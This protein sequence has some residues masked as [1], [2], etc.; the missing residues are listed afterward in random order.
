MKKSLSLLVAIA[1]VFSMFATVV[2][3]AEEPTAGEYLNELGVILGNQDGDL[4]EDQTWKRQDIVVLLSR[5]FGAEDEA[6]GA[7]KTHEFKD[8]TDKNYDGY[9][10]WAVEEGLVKGK[11]ATVFGFGDELENRDFYLLVLRALG[12]EVDYDKVG[13][14]A[15]EAGLAPEDT[16]FDDIPLRGE[17][18]TAI[19]AALK[20]E[21]EPG[22]TLEQKLGL[23]EIVDL[24]INK[25]AQTNKGEITVSFN[26]AATAD[27]QK[28]LKAKVA[29]GA[30][31]YTVTSKWAEDGKSL[32]LTSTYLPAATYTVTVGS[33]KAVD[34]TIVNEVP[35]KLEIGATTLQ[36]AA[37]Q[38]LKVKLFNQFGKEIENASL[39]VTVF[40]ATYGKTVAVSSGKV[41]LSSDEVAR[42]K[43]TVV[44]NA[45]HATTG[46]NASKSFEVVAGS[47]A[48]AIT[49]TAPTPLKDKTRISVTEEGLVLP[50]TLTDQYGGAIKLAET[51]GY[52]AIS[53]DKTITLS[54]ITFLV[55]DVNIVT[56]F[57]VDKD[58]VLKFKTGAQHGNVVVNAMNT[59]VAGAFASV[60]FNV[61]S[62]ADVKTLTLQAP[63]AIVAGNE[64]FTV[65]YSAVDTFDQPIATKDFSLTGLTFSPVGAS[66]AA[67]YPKLNAKGELKFKFQSLSADANVNVYVSKA[68]S[69]QIGH[70]QFT[71]RKDATVDKINGFNVAKNFANSGTV[72]LKADQIT[73]RDSYGRT[74]KVAALGDVAIS[75]T[76]GTALSITGGN[77]VANATLTGEVKIKVVYGG[78]D[79]TAETFTFNVIKNE[80][81][82]D[83][84]IKSIGTMYAGTVPTGVAVDA[85]EKTIELVGKTSGG[86][87]VVLNQATA[88]D[89]VSSEKSLIVQVKTGSPKTIKAVDAGTS[90]IAAYKG[91]TKL[92]Q[93]E[94]TA[95]KEAPV[96]TT[97]S[98]DN[99]EYTLTTASTNFATEIVVKDQYG[100][101]L[102]PGTHFAGFLS[103]DNTKVAT[104][105]GT[106]VVKGTERGSAIITYTTTTG[107]SA[108]T[109]V[110]V[111]S[112]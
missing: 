108:T 40:N 88:F 99:S 77:L 37:G 72:E 41:D 91:S 1:M 65:P 32:V 95:S 61:S 109:V 3:A 85:Y 111:E 7:K 46:L 84:A 25:V 9:I 49:L 35:S 6:K 43:D 56:H 104:I 93:V 38:D 76:S 81:V 13:E 50:Y 47:S 36:K 12:Q 64:E 83:Y 34:V 33:F 26:K 74:Q 8:V 75:V 102:V 66:F 89:F 4:K 23:V 5:L 16:D 42:V 48:T 112:I 27:E 94:V 69:G 92:A 10:S 53:S 107:A 97:A 63:A 70:Q 98:F 22:V 52:Q 101:A 86:D 110:Y 39:N 106:S 14:A 28:E 2:S 90:V 30:V 87:D 54:G 71:V 55:S 73:Y 15:V 44:V 29:N 24:A 68:A 67:G 57:S 80:D 60:N 59:T 20:T 19:V 79:A 11:S 105:S 31:E 21:V 100:V 51:S 96:A 18:Y 62:K 45:S 58:G 78:V 103:S 17:T 82:K